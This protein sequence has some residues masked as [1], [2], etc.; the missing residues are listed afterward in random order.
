M[1]TYLITTHYLKPTSTFIR[2]IIVGVMNTLVGL[3]S[4]F[5]LLQVG[6][7]SYWISTF[8]G[9]SIG[10]ACSYVLNRRFTFGSK[11]SFGRSIPLFMI[12]IMCCYFV[13]YSFSRVMA[14]LL[15]GSFGY[16]DY[17]NEIAVLL[18]TI[19]YTIT[20]YL[21]QKYFVFK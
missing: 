16:V 1:N 12:V 4:I 20:N 17:T 5:L 19:L 7:L 11:V 18:G 3:S 15:A 6:G 2:F 21:G 14:N 10:A 8:L 13:S 9:N